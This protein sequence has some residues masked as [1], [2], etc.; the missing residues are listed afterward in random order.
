MR[1]FE[2]YYPIKPMFVNQP[3]G[4]V[5]PVYTSMGL[6]GHNGI[7]FAAKHGQ[8]VYAAHD[9]IA[10]WENDGAS[11]MGVVLCS[12]EIFDY[13]GTPAKMKTLY[14]HLADPVKE[15]KLKSPIYGNI[16]VKVKRGDLIGYADNTG[17]STG[18]HLHFGLKPGYAGEP[19]ALFIKL[20]P[21]NGYAGAINPQPFF[22]GKYAVDG[23][24][25]P[26]LSKDDSDIYGLIKILK[27]GMRSDLVKRLQTLLIKNNWTIP[28]GATGY[29]GP[30]TLSA[31]TA[32]KANH[33]WLY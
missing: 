4:N 1:K 14:W 25:I 26:I 22:N 5:L 20:E 13:N 32:W 23:T 6:A 12:E 31:V 19:D 33:A 28:A 2:L 21:N 17:V 3:F 29:Y 15:P 7:D 18:D 27:Y 10:Y 9:G 8:P 11:G 30:Q 16:P 24:D